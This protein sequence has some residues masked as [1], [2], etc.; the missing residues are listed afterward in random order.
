MRSHVNR[1]RSVGTADI[2]QCIGDNSDPK[3]DGIDEYAGVGCRITGTPISNDCRLFCALPTQPCT[4]R[5][6]RKQAADSHLEQS[7]GTHASAKLLATRKRSGHFAKFIGRH[8]CTNKSLA[9]RRE[10]PCRATNQKKAACCCKSGLDVIA[11]WWHRESTSR[12]DGCYELNLG[13]APL[14]IG[15]KNGSPHPGSAIWASVPSGVWIT[16]RR[17]LLGSLWLSCS[18]F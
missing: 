17:V 1:E 2:C 3:N 16:V 13:E 6:Y 15:I 9:A 4:Q 18:R 8:K 7:H 10:E 12:R 5:D 14:A 11:H